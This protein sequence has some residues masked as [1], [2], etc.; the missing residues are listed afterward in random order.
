[1]QI[2][3]VFD[4]SALSVTAREEL[5]KFYPDAKRAHLKKGGNFPYLSVSDEVNLHIQ[6]DTILFSSLL[7]SQFLACFKP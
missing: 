4:E 5:Y 6:V 2:L 1:M 7:L 3:Q